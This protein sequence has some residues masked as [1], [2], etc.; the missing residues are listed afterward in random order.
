MKLLFKNGIVVDPSNNINEKLDILVENNK[1]SKIAKNIKLN[2]VEVI[3][4]ANKYLVPGLIDMHVH[5]REPGFEKKETILTGSKAAVKGGFT[6]VVCMPNTNP[7]IDNI[8]T[9]KYIKEKSKDAF[10]NIYFMGS[11]TK[12]L[13][14]KELSDTN[15]MYNNGIVGIT[16]DGMTVMDSKVMFEVLREAKKFDLITCSHC[17]DVNL[18]YDCTI[19]QG[20][21]SKKLGLIGRPNISEE[22]IIQ[23][24]ILLAKVLDA[25]I[26]IQHISTKDGVDLVRKAKAEGIKVSCEATPHHFTLTDKAIL[27]HGSNAKMSPPLRTKEDIEAV[28]EG[29][30]DG[31]IDIIATDHAPHTQKDKEGG[32]I[33]SANGIVGLETALSLAVTELVHKRSI[34]FE[35]IINKMSTMPAKLIN[36][37]RGTLQVGSDADITVIDINKEWTVDKNKFYSKGKNTPFDGMNLKGQVEM[38]IVNGDIKYK[39]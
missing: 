39:K 9:I 26:H 23:R 31:T 24:D 19:N 35:D 10:C 22:I 11:I 16:D 13:R 17:E 30:K 32:I 7:V 12:G 25:K 21:I 5:F 33:G 20:E 4:A 14:G 1:I 27:E 28:I 8:E 18:V 37:N 34:K 3:D 6:S 29:L 15:E 38:T 2:D 36:L